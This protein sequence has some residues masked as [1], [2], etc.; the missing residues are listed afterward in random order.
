MAQHGE[1]VVDDP[2][3]TR[4]HPPVESLQHESRRGARRDQIRRIDQ[5]RA[6]RCAREIAIG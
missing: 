4:K 3:G 5:A 2:R 1:K 6:E